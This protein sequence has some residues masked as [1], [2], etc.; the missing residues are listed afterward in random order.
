MTFVSFGKS[1][2]ISKNNLSYLQH[3]LTLNFCLNHGCS[4]FVS[5]PKINGHLYALTLQFI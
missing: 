5:L 4:Y 1:K 2:F 3:L